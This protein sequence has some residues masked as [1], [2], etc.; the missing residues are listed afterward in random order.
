MLTTIKEL[1]S[2][3]AQT[4]RV[5]EHTIQKMGLHHGIAPDGTEI[6][7][8]PLGSCIGAIQHAL[9][10][11]HAKYGRDMLQDARMMN[12]SLIVIDPKERDA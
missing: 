6:I 2:L 9:R 8:H 1:E 3:N 7:E 11:C 10:A 5:I 4:Q 12:G